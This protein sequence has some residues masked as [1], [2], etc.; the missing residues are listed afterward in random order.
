MCNTQ[1][2]EKF[3]YVPRPTIRGAI[4]NI[5]VGASL[6]FDLSRYNYIRMLASTL[7]VAGRIYRTTKDGKNNEL[8]VTRVQ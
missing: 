2:I 3:E 6:R 7:G 5:E 4:A 1:T 8:I